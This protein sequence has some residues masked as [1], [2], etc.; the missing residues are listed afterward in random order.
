MFYWYWW[1]LWL[2]LFINFLFISINENN[3][4]AESMFFVGVH[5]MELHLM[6]SSVNC[7]HN[8]YQ[9]KALYFATRLGWLATEFYDYTL[10]ISL[11]MLNLKLC[12]QLKHWHQSISKWIDKYCTDRVIYLSES[13]DHRWTKTIDEG[14]PLLSMSSIKLGLLKENDK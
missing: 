7:R 13:R 5:W 3:L 4:F 12:Q 6:W 11:P 8:A 10:S 1:N 2:L 14:G 9:N